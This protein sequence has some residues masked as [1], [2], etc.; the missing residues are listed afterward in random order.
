M[1]TFDEIEALTFDVFGTVVD[2]RSSIIREGEQ[3]AQ[4][5]GITADWA[6]FTDAWRGLYQP[7]MSKVR[8]GLRPWTR[9]DDL[10]RESLVELL[11]R[12]EI[13]GLS[14]AEIDDFNR[15]WHRLDPWPDAVEG[16]HRLKR[17]FILATLS[18]GNIALLVNMA[19]R[20]GLDW[21]VI[22]GAEPTRHYKPLPQAYLGTAKLLDLAPRQ[23]LM[24]AAHNGDL[25][26]ARAVGFRT[27]FVLRP[28]E[29]GPQQSTDIEPGSGYDVAAR[30]FLELATALGC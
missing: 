1:N 5:K 20:A 28:T 14:E 3:L 21:D 15:A 18:N 24:V 23:C 26:A 8:D 25:E 30:D 2:W 7:S 12:F 29:H 4:R 19:K 11:E 6:A 10:H 16:L 17:R 13:R 9:L 22:L 27:A